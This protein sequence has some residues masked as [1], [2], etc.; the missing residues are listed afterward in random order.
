[1]AILIFYA[2][3]R[4]YN[5]PV[6]KFHSVFKSAYHDVI[7]RTKKGDK[8]KNR[9]GIWIYFAQKNLHKLE[10]AIEKLLKQFWNTKTIHNS[11]KIYWKNIFT[12]L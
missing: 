12:A 9:S 3:I 10:L 7:V 11:N 2:N 6:E 8:I 1:M 4:V 5:G